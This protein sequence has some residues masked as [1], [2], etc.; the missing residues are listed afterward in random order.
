MFK[1]PSRDELIICPCKQRSECIDLG[2]LNNSLAFYLY[3]W[4]YLVLS[5][6]RAQNSSR[7]QAKADQLQKHQAVPLK[8]TLEPRPGILSL[9]T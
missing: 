4:Q 5:K 8:G 7:S 3:G 2:G 1:L 9:Q 6:L